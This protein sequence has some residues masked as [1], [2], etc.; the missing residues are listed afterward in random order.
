[1][2]LHFWNL[3]TISNLKYHQKS[4]NDNLAELQFTIKINSN[5]NGKFQLKIN[6]KVEIVSLKKGLNTI[7]SEYKI[8]NPKRWWTNGLGDANLYAFEISLSQNDKILHSNKLNIGLRTIEL[9]K[10][11]DT[12][13][14]S[15]YFKL[16]GIPV[17]MK[18]ANYIPPDSFLPRATDSVY[19]NIVKNAVDSNMNM[20]R[21]WGGG[22]YAED[23]FYDECDKKGILVW[24]DFMFACAMYPGDKDF[25][26]NVKKEVIDNVN[27]LQNHP[28]IA[29][30][31]GNNENDEGWK[32]WGWQ[33]QYQYSKS[34]STKIWNDYKKLFNE[35]IPQTLDS[36]LSNKENRYWPSSPSIG[37]GKKESLLEGDSH[38]WG[39]WWGKEP[40]EIYEKKVGRFMSEYGFQGM[41]NLETFKS[42]ANNEDLNLNSEAVKSHQ[43]HATGYQ[44]INEYMARD[45]HVPTSFDDYIYVSQLLQASGMKIAIEAHR[46]AKPNC[47]GTLFWQLND[48][49]SVTSWSAVDYYGRWK[50][51]QY[52]A[53]KSFENLMISVVEEGD[54]YKVYVVNDNLLSLQGEIN[55]ELIDFNGKKLW[56]NNVNTMLPENSS[57]VQ[58]T[59]SKKDFEKFPLNNAVLSVSFKSEISSVNS[60]YYFVKPKD[61]ALSHPNIQL[62]FIDD[63]TLEITSNV[64]AK[65]VY[66][67]TSEEV[68]F[69]DN[70]FDILPNNKVIIKLPKPLKNIKV[71]SLFDTLK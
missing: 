28:S 1:V 24:Q 33:K 66:I 38:Y 69:S 40:F 30:W 37:W 23:A 35:L 62:K 61:L 48:C 57:S 20:L 55:L 17:F 44:T 42:F 36:L 22:V 21:V 49:W 43:K 51:F 52:Q 6:D 50:A 31:C 9:V 41:P 7:T 10:E 3:A 5:T 27:R 56:K 11:K 12:I 14:K 18:G 26:Q 47:M 58:F 54:F 19:K 32:N 29:L 70:Y 63:F 25:L 65:N 34:D 71:K 13:G 53:K 64:L 59:I 68:I 39:I 67:Q 46:R 8:Q 45:F 16:N 2:K 4:L 60:L 15:F